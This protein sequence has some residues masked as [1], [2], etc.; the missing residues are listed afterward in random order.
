MVRKATIQKRNSPRLTLL[1]MN[2]GETVIIPTRHIQTPAIRTAA[3]RME[4]KKEGRFVIT[5]QGLVNET[6]VTRIK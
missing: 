5:T 2:I 3:T 6:Q 4:Q 1:G